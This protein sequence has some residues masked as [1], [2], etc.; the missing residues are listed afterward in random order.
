MKVMVVRLIIVGLFALGFTA[1]SLGSEGVKGAK[2]L[3]WEKGL[4]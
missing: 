2:L 4:P 3:L 1:Q